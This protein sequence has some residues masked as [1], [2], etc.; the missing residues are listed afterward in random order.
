MVDWDDILPKIFTDTRFHQTGRARFQIHIDGTRAGIAVA[1]RSAN[2]D[3]HT[4][5]MQDYE[6]LLELKRAN[7]FDAAFVV[8]ATSIKS[9]HSLRRVQTYVAHIDAEKLSTN[10]KSMPIDGKFGP[11]W[12]LSPYDFGDHADAD[13]IPY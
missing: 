5:N 6:A 12:L 8:A 7:K 11:F 1:W 9:G 4:L 3:N 10:L 13:D 2:F